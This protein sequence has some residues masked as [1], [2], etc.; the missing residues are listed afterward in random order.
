MSKKEEGCGN[1]L[2]GPEKVMEIDSPKSVV[3]LD[4]NSW[5][6]KNLVTLVSFLDPKSWFASTVER[7]GK[8]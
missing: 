1:S 3:T 6:V 4:H 2:V 7:V 5:K 8:S